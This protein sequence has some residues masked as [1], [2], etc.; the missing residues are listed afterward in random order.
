MAPK[1]SGMEVWLI[2]VNHHQRERLIFLFYLLLLCYYGYR[3]TTRTIIKTK[4]LNSLNPFQSM[5]ERP[6]S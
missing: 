5:C 3:Q 1:K 4:V 2:P 6:L